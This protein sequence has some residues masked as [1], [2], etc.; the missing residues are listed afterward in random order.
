VG[1]G[2]S[3]DGGYKRGPNLMVFVWMLWI[4]FHI[5]SRSTFPL[6]IAIVTATVLPQLVQLVESSRSSRAARD[7]RLI[8]PI[9]T[10]DETVAVA[11]ST[12]R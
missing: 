12:V 4:W 9:V 11:Y 1:G 2:S 6:S 8:H 3:T 10:F 5:E 7:R